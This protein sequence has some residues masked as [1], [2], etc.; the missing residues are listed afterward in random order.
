MCW[1]DWAHYQCDYPAQPVLANA[2]VM[3]ASSLARP[4]DD[5]GT[6]DG[7]WMSRKRAAD[8]ASRIA[9]WQRW[10]SRRA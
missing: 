8:V 6:I 7:R 10:C 2:K 4:G 9:R 3:V 5:R 1:N